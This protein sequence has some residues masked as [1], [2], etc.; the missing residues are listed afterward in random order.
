MAAY[1]IVNITVKDPVAF[2]E[3]RAAVPALVS[4]HGGE[5]LVRGGRCEVLEG[6]WQPKR[7]VVFR[8]PDMAAIHAFDGDP[9]YQPWKALRQRAAETELVAV[10]GV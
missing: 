8:F 1:L 9:E 3:Y 10:E 7:L 6:G 4:K 5:Y 2:E